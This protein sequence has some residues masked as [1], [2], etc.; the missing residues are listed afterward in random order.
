MAF[1]HGI[2]ELTCTV[3][4]RVVCIHVS[5]SKNLEL[6]NSHLRHL[7]VCNRLPHSF[8]WQYG[9]SI[10]WSKGVQY[11]RGCIRVISRVTNYRYT[12]APILF[13][14]QTHTH[15]LFGFVLRHGVWEH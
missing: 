8:N 2:D 1:L 9:L 6:V 13:W 10:I 14:L 4:H 12:V 5:Q 15:P 11:L 3:W 7:D